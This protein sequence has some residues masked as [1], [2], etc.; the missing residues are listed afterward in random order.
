MSAAVDPSNVDELALWDG[1]RGAFWAK[2]ADR[3]DEGV[4]GYHDQLLDA[5]EITGT[6]TVLDIGCGSGQTARDAA[7]RAKAVTGIDLSARM[8]ELGRRLAT[9]EHLTN[10]EFVQG[11]AQVHP[12]PDAHF[13]VAISRNG[14]MFFGDPVAAFT[15]I[16]R[17][18]RPGGRIAL[19]SWQQPNRNEWV[20]LFFRAL[21]DDARPAPAQARN[22]LGFSEPDSMRAILTEAGFTD[23]RFTSL[24]EPMYF[25]T[26]ADDASAFVAEQVGLDPS[27]PAAAA[28]IAAMR[29]DMAQHQTADGVFY[30]SA[31]WLTQAVR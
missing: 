22:P 29:A 26:D 14:V 15:N 28:K 21:Q 16:A 5:A 27:D 6:D 7:R 11:D 8:L 23:I 2:R 10:V 18:L 24:T 9:G 25:G 30:G 20:G 19:L 13:D 4:R 31:A 12:F 3:I 1:P 17:A